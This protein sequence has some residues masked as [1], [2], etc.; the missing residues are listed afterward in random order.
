MVPVHGMSTDVYHTYSSA[1]PQTSRLTHRTVP[2]THPLPTPQ[3]HT[4]LHISYPDNMKFS[5]VAVLGLS[6]A[7]EAFVAPTAGRLGLVRVLG[8]GP[9][10][11]RIRLYNMFPCTTSGLRLTLM[12]TTCPPLSG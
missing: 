5:T 4:R 6:T 9:R 8:R 2:D 12:S 7:T 3:P 1:V 11:T 10:G